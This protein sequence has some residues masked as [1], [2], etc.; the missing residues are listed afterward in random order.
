MPDLILFIPGPEV[1]AVHGKLLEL[2]ATLREGALA[3][4]GVPDDGLPRNCLQ[5]LEALEDASHALTGPIKAAG[6]RAHAAREL[7]R[8][9]HNLDTYR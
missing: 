9:S 3:L 5:R 7:A 8:T 1:K 6:R 4:S 2:A